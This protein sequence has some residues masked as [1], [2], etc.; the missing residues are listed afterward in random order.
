[1]S[2]LQHDVQ[3]ITLRQTFR[4]IKSDYVRL[5]E[6]MH[7]SLTVGRIVFSAVSPT[8]VA[9]TLYRLSRYLYCRNLRPFAWLLYNG[10]CFLTGA[11]IAPTTS[12]GRSCLLGHANGMILCGRIGDNV[13]F[14]ARCGLGGG[15]SSDNIGGGAGLPVLEDNV[16]V[17]ACS[18]VLGPVRIGRDA[19]IAPHTLVLED[20]AAGATAM[21]YQRLVVRSR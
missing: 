18:S 14:Y 15:R 8:I 9:L 21:S 7:V 3:R 11:D 12:I 10:N 17:G 13:T 5:A 4:H 2:E 6:A 1:M 16:I 20:V 19:I